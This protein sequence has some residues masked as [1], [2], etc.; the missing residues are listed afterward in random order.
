MDRRRAGSPVLDQTSPGFSPVV[1]ATKLKKPPP[2]SGYA[3]K[4]AFLPSHAETALRSGMAFRKEAGRALAASV[5]RHAIWPLNR[6]LLK[7]AF[8]RSADQTPSQ[9]I[10]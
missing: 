1:M 3:M 8:D 4:C 2:L 5:V 6:A 10:T 7:P 9:A